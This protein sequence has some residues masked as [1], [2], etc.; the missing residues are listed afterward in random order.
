MEN[1]EFFG[2]QNYKER[3]EAER[4]QRELGIDG[5]NPEEGWP[6]MLTPD[7]ECIAIIDYRPTAMTWQEIRETIARCAPEEEI[8]KLLYLARG[9]ATWSRLRKL[10][11]IIE[12]VRECE[13]KGISRSPEKG[14]IGEEELK[15]L[16]HVAR[17]DHWP[18]DS[19]VYW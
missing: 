8:G 14:P 17:K 15:R 2:Y 6:V 12:Y 1:F 7:T 9:Y 16:E 10:G 4:R 5:D 11:G 19:P 13:A 3:M 18:L